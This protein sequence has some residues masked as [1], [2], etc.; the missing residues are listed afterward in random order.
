VER[1]R[2]LV[3]DAERSGYT[4]ADLITMIEEAT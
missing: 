4:R 2:A 1:V 3:D